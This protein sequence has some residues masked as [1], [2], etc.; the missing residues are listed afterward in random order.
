MRWV[1]L[2]TDRG[3]IIAAL[4]GWLIFTTTTRLNVP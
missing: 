1:A 4:A 2:H 3:L